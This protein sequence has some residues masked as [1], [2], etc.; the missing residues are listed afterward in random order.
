VTPAE[1]KESHNFK[2]GE[3]NRSR[4]RKKSEVCEQVKNESHESKK[5]RVETKVQPE[6]MAQPE[7]TVRTELKTNTQGKNVRP[8]TEPLRERIVLR[9]PEHIHHLQ[10]THSDAQR[11][12][13]ERPE[14]DHFAN[15]QATFEP[16]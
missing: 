3:R 15:V 7:K 14:P 16:D 2:L 13:R 6:T 5:A 12:R 10:Q 9:S 4:A 11:Q 8:M 1:R